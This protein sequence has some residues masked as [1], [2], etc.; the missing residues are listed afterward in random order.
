M[1]R[2]LAPRY[3]GLLIAIGSLALVP[4]WVKNPY[5]LS[6]LTFAALY[7]I[8][9]SSWNIPSADIG[10]LNFG[11]A[12]FFGAGAYATGSWLR[13]CPRSLS[14][15]PAAAVAV[16][17]AS[18]WGS[19]ASSCAALTCPLPRSCSRSSWS[20]SPS[21][22]RRDWRRVR[23]NR[24]LTTFAHRPLLCLARSSAR[25]ARDPAGSR[26]NRGSAGRSERSAT[27]S[28]QRWRRA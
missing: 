7:A 15:R 17:V 28:R 10:Q 18:S 13:T 9:A 27:T 24:R 3:L 5:I 19:P 20:G 8:F 26:R 21:P 6:V 12:V 4:F 11:H 16:A 23:D 1:T 25:D 2:R 14:S 22:S